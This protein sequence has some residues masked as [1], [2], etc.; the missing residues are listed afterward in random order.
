M[1]KKKD[2]FVDKVIHSIKRDIETG[3][4]AV[5][6]ALP[7]EPYLIKEFGVSR[8]VIREVLAA[9]KAEGVIETRQGSGVYVQSP[10][11]PSRENTLFSLSYDDFADILE[12]LE[13]RMA[14]EVEA[15]GLAAQR[16]TTAQRMKIFQELERMNAL[17]EKGESAED[18]DYEFH[19]GIAAATNNK[20]FVVFFSFIPNKMITRSRFSTNPTDPKRQNEYLMELYE[21]HRE[22]YEA[23]AQQDP[24]QAREKMRT[25][26]TNSKLRYESK[27]FDLPIKKT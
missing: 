1:I 13:L 25:H 21:E 8:T 16:H 11:E 20:R 5:G 12:F 15:A 2:S 3:R 22:V 4:Y 19:K 6:A 10:P 27:L 23:I 24:G 18:A 7:S 26:L 9:L 14:M 17:I